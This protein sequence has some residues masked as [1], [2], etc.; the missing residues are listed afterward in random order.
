M[1]RRHGVVTV[2]RIFLVFKSAPIQVTNQLGPNLSFIMMMFDIG[3]TVNRVCR[4]TNSELL[5]NLVL[6][7]SCM[8]TK[9]VD[10][11]LWNENF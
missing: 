3:S 2:K 7:V 10:L 4:I 5:L 11:K 9:V 6:P 1:I 8:S